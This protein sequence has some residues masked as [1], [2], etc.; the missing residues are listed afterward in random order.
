MSVEENKEIVRQW[1]M[2]RNTNNLD[3]ALR[4][5]VSEMHERLM[6]G[7]NGMTNAFPDIQIMIDDILG[8]G[9]KVIVRWTMNATHGGPYQNIPATQKRIT[10]TGIDIYSI[11]NGKINTIVRES[12]NLGLL[13]QLGVALSWQGEVIT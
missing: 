8:E 10:I 4:M 7:F 1:I 2:A 6:A 12:D 5:W 3:G 9:G 13:K 11:E